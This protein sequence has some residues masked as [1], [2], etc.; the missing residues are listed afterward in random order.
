MVLCNPIVVYYMSN[1]VLLCI[2]IVEICFFTDNLDLGP[3]S[4]NIS[5]SLK[6]S[7]WRFVLTCFCHVNFW[8]RCNPRYF[9]SCHY[10]ANLPTPKTRLSYN[11]S[12]IRSLFYS[13]GAAPTENTASSIVACWF[14]AAEM[15]L[16]HLWLVT[17]AAMT[18]ENTA[19]LLL[20]AFASA[21]MCL[22]SCCLAINY[23]DFQASCHSILYSFVNFC[24]SMFCIYKPN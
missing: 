2:C 23:S 9:S 1:W 22:Q 12:C 10:S 4:Q 20:R 3:R 11:S 18:T 15:C 6:F 16:P 14:T 21:G 5:R 17:T 8:S 13:L 19:F 24:G 7:C